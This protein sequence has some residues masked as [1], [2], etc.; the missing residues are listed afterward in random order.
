MFEKIL[1]VCTG[2]ICRS[3]IAEQLLQQA[4]P[5][6][7]IKSAGIAT[8]AAKLSGHDIDQTAREVAEANGLTLQ[9]HRAQ[10]ADRHIIADH[11]LVLVLEQKQKEILSQR[12]PEA[13]GKIML[14]G[15]WLTD[16]SH[17]QGQDIADPYRKSKDFHQQ[18]LGQLQQAVTQWSQKL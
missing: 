16:G 3:P 15:Q 11:D 2:N 18:V 14:L 6:K 1:I 17:G 10:Q 4:R 8:D 9:P 12:Y 5:D 13:R 7:T